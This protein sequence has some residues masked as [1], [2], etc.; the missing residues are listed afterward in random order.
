MHSNVLSLISLMVYLGLVLLPLCIS[1]TLNLSPRPFPD[2]LSSY[3]AMIG[4]NVILLEFLSSGHQ[5]LLSRILGI[6]WVLQTHQLFARLAV[7]LLLIHPFLYTLPNKPTGIYIPS[8]SDFVGLNLGSSLTGMLALIT[9]IIL[10]G[11]ALTRQNSVLRYETWRASH[12]M[13]ALLVALLGFHHTTHAGR[14]SQDDWVLGYWQIALAFAL[15]S[16]AWMYLIQPFIQSRNPYKVTSIR[17]VSANIWELV[18][19]QFESSNHPS[20]N[21]KYQAG[22]FAWL[23]IGQPYPLFENPFSIASCPDKN[24]T[25]LKFLIKNVGDF[26][27]QVTQLQPGDRIYLDGP[28]GNFG[29]SLFDPEKKDVV[30]IVGGVG[31]APALSLLRALASSHAVQSDKKIVLITGNRIEEQVIDLTSMVSLDHLQEFKQIKIIAEPK[32]HWTG[33]VGILDKDTLNRVLKSSGTNISNAHY[34]VCGPAG[35]IDAVEN[36]LDHMGVPLSQI[37]SEKFQYDF[38]KKNP[39]NHRSSIT[40]LVAASTLIALATYWA[41]R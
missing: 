13:M 25:Q 23:K 15:L 20:K 19:D 18:I 28:Y 14:L 1:Q 9:L 21:L 36:A 40:A 16:I 32:E 5:K 35:M 39:R 24:C 33:E 2:E 8:G 10:V 6:D 38:S 26:T 31:I 37:D 17:E 22:Q 7:L 12:A 27:Y 41:M 11:L 4:F 29:Q 3:L 30:F 34:F